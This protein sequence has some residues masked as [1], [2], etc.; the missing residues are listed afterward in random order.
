[1]AI[2]WS[3][4]HH[5]WTNPCI[6]RHPP[7]SDAYFFTSRMKKNLLPKVG[8]VVFGGIGVGI[9][10]PS[11]NAVISIRVSDKDKGK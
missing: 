7:F 4:I 9:L 8:T 3:Q 5:F 11:F 2:Y 10:T 1:M 6:L